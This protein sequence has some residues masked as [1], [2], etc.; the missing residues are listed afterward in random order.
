MVRL[1]SL[2]E[3]RYCDVPFRGIVVSG[4]GG[5]LTVDFLEPIT[6][7][8]FSG[9]SVRTGCWLGQHDPAPR[10]LSSPELAWEDVGG[11]AAHGIYLRESGK[12]K[13]LAAVAP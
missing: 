11:D 4:G 13:A 9:R 5:G 7:E 10:V 3:G 12:R 1:G 8:L 2:V 6:L